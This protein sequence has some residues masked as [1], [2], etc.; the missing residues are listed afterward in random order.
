MSYCLPISHLSNIV[1][2]T[3]GCVLSI[4]HNKQAI[5]NCPIYLRLLQRFQNSR[6]RNSLAALATPHTLVLDRSVKSCQHE[7]LELDSIFNVWLAFHF[8]HDK[9]TVYRQQRPFARIVCAEENENGY[10]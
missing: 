9:G 6:A 2:N 10:H 8:D 3:P 1:C 7:M 5:H 4:A